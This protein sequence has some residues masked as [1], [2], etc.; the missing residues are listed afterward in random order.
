MTTEL[1]YTIDHVHMLQAENKKLQQRISELE[2]IV[3]FESPLRILDERTRENEKLQAKVAMLRD[4][5]SS[6]RN[7]MSDRNDITPKV[8][9]ALSESSSDW[10]T[11]HD[12][13][14]RDAAYAKGR[15]DMHDEV[16]SEWHKPA[17]VGDAHIGDRLRKLKGT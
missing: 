11:Q 3:L 16:M 9:Y 12:Q 17:Q 4:A 10:I 5:L 13:Q 1:S 2:G 15:Q 8:D 7:W 14:V 6:A